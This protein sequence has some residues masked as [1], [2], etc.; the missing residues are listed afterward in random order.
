[1][2]QRAANNYA[3]IDSQNVNLAIKE[4]GW[5][6]DFRRLRKY[7]A[8][9][10][11]VTQAYLFLGLIPEYQGLYTALQK[12]GFILI[13]K[14]TL[15]AKDGK[16]KGNCDAELVLHT[17][18]EYPHYDKAVIVTG[19]GDFFCLIEYLGDK[20]KLERLLIPN[21]RKYSSLLNRVA[22]EKMIFLNRSRKKLEYKK[23]K[24][25]A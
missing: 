2:S 23:L 10:Y 1:M 20:D 11:H 4:L 9:K 14:P 21:E 17:M 19:D 13:F 15:R 3:F 24:G 6:L 5:S 12:A 22:I 8:D 18:I 7:L 16:V 25:T